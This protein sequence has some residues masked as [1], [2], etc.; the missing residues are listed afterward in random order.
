[1]DE[2]IDGSEWINTR[3]AAKLTN[4]TAEYVRRLAREGKIQSKL[5]GFSRMIDRGSL[6]EYQRARNAA[7]E[8]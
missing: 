2:R 5:V 1:M 7:K 6:L 8:R 3:E 4:Y